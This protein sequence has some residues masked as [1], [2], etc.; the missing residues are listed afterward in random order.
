MRSDHT[1]QSIAQSAFAQFTCAPLRRHS[2]TQAFTINAPLFASLHLRTAIFINIAIIA[3]VSLICRFAITIRH[4]RRQQRQANNNGQAN[5]IYSNAA[6]CHQHQRFRPGHSTTL[7][8]IYGRRCFG[9]PTPA[10]GQAL[11]S[12]ADIAIR[13]ICRYRCHCSGATPYSIFTTANIWP[14]RRRD[15]RQ[16]TGYGILPGRSAGRLSQVDAGGP[17]ALASGRITAGIDRPQ[18][19]TQPDL[20][21]SG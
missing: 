8:I 7:L 15:G 2:L 9:S 4:D 20:A 19:A 5:T 3:L 11:G 18:R 13:P 1:P 12:R 6:A 17:G 16:R 21:Q 14:G 10:A